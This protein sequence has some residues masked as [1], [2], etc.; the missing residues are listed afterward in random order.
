MKLLLSLGVAVAVLVGIKLRSSR[1][2]E[3][4][5]HQVTN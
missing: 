5:W 2:S 1:N 4:V 3:D